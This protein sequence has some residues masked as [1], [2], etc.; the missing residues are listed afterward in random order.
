MDCLHCT[1]QNEIDLHGTD[2]HHPSHWVAFRVGIVTAE[3][4]GEPV[5]ALVTT[6]EDP[7]AISTDVATRLIDG[8][9]GCITVHDR[10]TTER[11]AHWQET[12]RRLVQAAVLTQ[13]QWRAVLDGLTSASPDRH[14]AA[15]AA[16]ADAAP[17]R[18]PRP[19]AAQ[20]GSDRKR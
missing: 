8:L 7:I 19:D 20:L 6:N 5:I 2:A 18:W 1:W 13:S 17:P 10:L 14:R 3:T 15:V 11:E 4:S 16:L 9:R 12:A